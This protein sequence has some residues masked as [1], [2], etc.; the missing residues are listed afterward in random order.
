MKIFGVES[1]SKSQ[2]I[3]VQPGNLPQGLTAYLRTRAHLAS[4]ES[5]FHCDPACT[6]PG[7]KNHDLQVPVS[8]VDL[9]G[10]AWHR[11]ESVS[12][13]YPRHYSLGLFANE[14]EDWLRMVS[15]K[16]NKP[17][18]F[19]EN[20][21]CSI[22][23]VRPLPCILFPEYLVY[24][25]TF[26]ANAK[27]D[28]FRDYLCLQRPLPL[29]PDRAKVLAKLRRMWEREILVTSFFLFNHGPC[30]LDFS[31]LTQELLKAAGSP[32]EAA[33]EEGPATPRAI[34]NQVLD[35]FFEERIAGCQPFAGVGE[36]I[37]RLD[38]REAQVQ[39]L[40]FLQD[41]LFM[42]K[43]IQGEDLV[44]RFIKGKLKAQRRSLIPTEYKFYQ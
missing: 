24:E 26:E 33:S 43:L 25:N 3:S 13:N 11:Q 29:S 16:L 10:A 2:G 38:N 23:P 32:Q 40:Q 42:K 44:F 19:L 12:E 37:N 41:D 18:P 15:L 22:Y 17:C 31:N 14:R 39:F 1:W 34:T 21:F 28:C 20:D 5:D 4:A 36:K 27:K 30:H 9:L 7:C 6:R 35:Q 8:L